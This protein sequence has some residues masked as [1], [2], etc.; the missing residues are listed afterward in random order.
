MAAAPLHFVLVPLPAQGHVIPMMDMA[1]LIAGHG[2]GG[3]RVTVV[4]TP[5]MAARH[6]AAVAHAAR[7]GLA[8]DVSVLE[9]PAGAGLAAGC[10]SYDMVA[11]M[12]LFKTFTDAVWRLAAPLEAFLRALPR[13]PDCVVADS[14]SPWTAGS[15]G[16]SACRGSC[17]MARRRCTSSRC[18]TWRGTACTTASPATLSRSTCRTCRRRAP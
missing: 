12:S 18:I 2:G 1:R 3:A 16:G 13:R 15:R 17:S 5:V 8:V 11:D 14:C 6:R 9:F 10:E 4:L 7:S